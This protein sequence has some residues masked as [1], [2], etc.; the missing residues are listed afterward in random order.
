MKNM[1]TK[2]NTIDEVKDLRIKNINQQVYIKMLEEELEQLKNKPKYDKETKYT[3]VY[4]EMSC[5]DWGFEINGEWRG[6]N[7][8]VTPIEYDDELLDYVL[9]RLKE[10]IKGGHS[11]F[12]SLMD[13]FQSED[14]EFDK[15]SCDTCGHSG[16]KTIWKI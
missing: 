5:T 6:A 4:D 16:Y 12:K 10:E 2:P 1:E 11:D 13:C 3:I 8:N 7:S 9:T 15:G 14:T